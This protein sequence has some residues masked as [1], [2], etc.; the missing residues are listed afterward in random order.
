MSYTSE[1]IEQLEAK[2]VANYNATK[3]TLKKLKQLKP[4]VMDKKI[5]AL[6]EK[7]FEKI[8]CLE[9]ARCC[10][11]ISPAM[12]PSDLRRMASF[13]KTTSSKLIDTYL[14]TDDEGDFV[15]RSQPCP[16]LGENH[17]CAIY[18]A[19]PKACRDYPHTDRKRFH[20]ILNLT[21]RNS[22][23]CPAVFNIIEKM[24]KELGRT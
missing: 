5:H 21:A 17:L 4:Q 2:A 6:H 24:K 14:Q 9:C 7:E 1:S 19:R 15:F 3:K 8:D 18:P 12:Y 22:K 16:F 13:M 23:I 11:N 10:K 20:Q